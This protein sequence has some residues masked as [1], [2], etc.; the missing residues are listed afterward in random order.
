MSSFV[1]SV[2]A[3]GRGLSR[4]LPVVVLILAVAGGAAAQTGPQ[5]YVPEVG[6]EGKDVIWVPTEQSLVQRMLDI[7]KVTPQDYLIDLGSGDG[8][9]V[10]AAAKRGL[11]AHGI[12]FNPKMVTLARDNAA[13]AGVTGR[14]TFE[15]GDIFEK[16]FSK[17]DILTM[18][19]L[20]EINERLR[21]KILEMKPGTRVVTNTF[22]MGDWP[23][24]DTAHISNCQDFCTTMLWIV[25]AK[26]EGTWRLGDRELR[27]KQEFQMLR[28]TLGAASISAARLRGVEITFV[29]NGVQYKGTVSGKEI[30]GKSN[31]AAASSW[32]A[33]RQ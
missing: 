2:G 27:L 13:K 33:T 3:A 29:A 10:I 11:R 1:R 16:D 17:A 31:D 18:F 15:R 23:A 24:D 22:S 19:L 20:D 6:Q 14:A 7:A 12:E 5:P 21:P 8:R 25:P 32:T 4:V 26:V 9:T 28:G 30:S